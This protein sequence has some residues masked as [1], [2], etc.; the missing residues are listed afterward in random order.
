MGLSTAERSSDSFGGGMTRRVKA[1]TDHQ[2]MTKTKQNTVNFP[3]FEDN[4]CEKDSLADCEAILVCLQN[5][6]FVIARPDEPRDLWPLDGGWENLRELKPGDEVVY[7]GVRT[8]VRA[9]DVYR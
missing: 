6:R 4:S 5:R 2:A 1:S 7:K 8:I 9:L 3:H